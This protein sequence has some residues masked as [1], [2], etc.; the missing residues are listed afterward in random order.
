DRRR[1]GR[2]QYEGGKEN[3]DRLARRRRR[4]GVLDPGRRLG[5]GGRGSLVSREVERGVLVENR[6]EQALEILT[7]LGPEIL[8]GTGP[9][10]VVRL[11]RLLRAWRRVEREHELPAETLPT[12][13][14]GD[15]RLEL[16]DERRVPAERERSLDP[17]LGCEQPQLLEPRALG[18]R[19]LLEGEL[20]E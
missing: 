14:L 4:R 10:P 1:A 8:D 18:P 9:R 13:V 6:L 11:E 17:F 20:G 15:E 2:S 3:G 16:A 5:S 7:R 19:K 12:R